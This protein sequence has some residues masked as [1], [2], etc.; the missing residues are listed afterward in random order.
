MS[1]IIQQKKKKPIKRHFY[2]KSRGILP[3]FKD[4]QKKRASLT[5][6]CSYSMP[7]PN[8]IANKSLIINNMDIYDDT[9][10]LS[11][12][13]NKDDIIPL[14]DELKINSETLPV[15]EENGLDLDE[16]LNMVYID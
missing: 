8:T 15:S 16:P 5:L 9:I 3:F 2:S 7:I 6:M 13:N 14:P 4:K 12:T 1:S 11:D 10:P